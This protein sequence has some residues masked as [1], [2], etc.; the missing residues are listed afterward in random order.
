MDADTYGNI[1]FGG[2]GYSDASNK[3]L[4]MVAYI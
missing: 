2:V 1:A 3:N 4:P